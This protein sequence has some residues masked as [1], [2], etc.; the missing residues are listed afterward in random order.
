M[1]EELAAGLVEHYD[2]PPNRNRNPLDLY[3]P[4][5][6]DDQ[7]FS[8]RED[9]FCKILVEVSD[10]DRDYFTIELVNP[11]WTEEIQERFVD[12]ASVDT[13]DDVIVVSIELSTEDTM[14]IRELAYRFRNI[15]GY[16]E[17][18]KNWAWVSRRADDSL[19]ELAEAIEWIAWV[20][21]PDHP[22]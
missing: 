14:D 12:R 9:L 6:V 5:R 17:R 22:W 15:R 10:C 2:T 13:V 8:D 21:V 4:I 16:D 19:V 18:N 7:T 11:P 20:D 1:N 3:S